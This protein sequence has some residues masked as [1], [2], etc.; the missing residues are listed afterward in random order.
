[1]LKPKFRLLETDYYQLSMV[2]A[3]ILL[4]QANDRAGFEA[5]FR[6]MNPNI[7]SDDFYYFGGHFEV[8]NFINQIKKE[9]QDPEFINVFLKLVIPKLPQDRVEEYEKSLRE[10]WDNLEK[11][12]EFSVYPLSGMIKPFVPAFQ[13]NGPKWIGQLLETPILNII[14][15]ET[16]FLT[17]SK[18]SIGE[19]DKAMEVS[20]LATLFNSSFT[21][22]YEH[23]GIMPSYREELKERAKE[24]RES[25]SKILL[26][27]GFRRAPTFDCALW[28]SVIALDSGWDGT[29]N[30]SI[31]F[32]TKLGDSKIGGTMAHSFVM[33]QTD[34]LDAYMLWNQIYPN[35][36]LLID[37][38]G[39]DEALHML[40]NLDIKPACVRID[41]EPLDEWAM[42][43]RHVLDFQFGW[44]D[45][46]IFISGDLT[47]ERLKDFE[48]REIPF[49]MCMAGTEYVNYEIGKSLNCG[50]V[51]KLVEF[52]KDGVTYYPEKKSKNKGNRGSLKG[53]YYDDKNI[54]IVGNTG[55]IG[56]HN[57]PAHMKVDDVL[58]S[59]K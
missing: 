54:L 51:Y 18:L 24:Y 6:R 56:F 19:T 32:E 40:Y 10:K 46:K 43:T 4:D 30:T 39:I 27:A 52:E 22:P 55:K 21:S 47:P 14:N 26:E 57:L 20:L 23:R 59:F 50:F 29:S 44:E 1:M 49:D 28:G 45:V 36:T 5:F 34:E 16:G 11:D 53:L 41:S 13:Y 2:T 58:W 38:Y 8:I 35:S 15:G 9:L 25:T 31:A 12:F 17:K 37:T 48:E 3:Y 33:S 7:T 42:H